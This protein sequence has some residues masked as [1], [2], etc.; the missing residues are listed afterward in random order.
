MSLACVAAP[1]ANAALNPVWLDSS[2]LAEGG[3]ET[4]A[5]RLAS[6]HGRTVVVWKQS[7]GSNTRLYASLRGTDGTWSGAE[8]ISAAGQDV[9]YDNFRVAAD[10]DGDF[11]VGW[12]QDGGNLPVFT[13]T[14]A[15]TSSEWA[16]EP[17]L[18]SESDGAWDFEFSSPAD[19][20][21]VAWYATA[22]D[23]YKVR[24]RTMRPGSDT[25][26]PA[27]VDIESGS[28]PSS[29][30]VAYNASGD[31][32]AVWAA[33]PDS[34]YHL[35]ASRYDAVDATWSPPVDVTAPAANVIQATFLAITPTG[36]A[37]VVWGSESDMIGRNAS[38][39]A[40]SDTWV[41]QDPL[42]EGDRVLVG[43]GLAG[44]RGGNI[45]VGYSEWD[46]A[47]MA[48][49]RPL[50]RIRD[51]ATGAWSTPEQLL[52]DGVAGF[53]TGATA[54]P[55]GN[56]VATLLTTTDFSTVYVTA[57]YRPAGAT[58][59]TDN[60]SLGTMPLEFSHGVPVST[61]D[62]R[63]NPVVV[64]PKHGSGEVLVNA[65]IGD[66][67][68]PELSGLSV[69]TSGTVG[70]PLSFSVSPFDLL[71][72]M[73]TTSWSF[74]DSRD[75]TGT[76]VSHTYDAP[77]SYALTVTSRDL[78]G[79]TSSET[80]TIT[81]TSPPAAPVDEPD[82]AAPAPPKVLA[83]VLEARLSGKTITLNTRVTL[84]AG[85]KC[86]GRATAT[87]SF[88]NTTY[89]TTLKL[90]KVNGKCVGTGTIKLKKTPS[91]RTKLRV[92]V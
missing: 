5:P 62:E 73:D 60:Q 70:E 24:F 66:A 35:R 20:S 75:A 3:S 2:T 52:D 9:N 37:T 92:T 86:T 22:S 40:G 26:D 28:N 33:H 6:S 34:N 25:W 82:D 85:K 51:A 53:M 72:G 65:A 87:T 10:A 57:L 15:N 68:G 76:S 13:L 27:P 7:D 45:V 23:P 1:A 49:T 69:P 43:L 81:I 89:R 78:R 11:T 38:V 4:F 44:D 67:T 79:Q 30:S 50:S 8:P 18:L 91:T 84:R 83:P 17:Q 31:G 32:I 19:G 56:I 80:R 16:D 90:A 77:G 64:W 46:G 59:F 63:G 47:N 74:G 36:A 88:G 54:D 58:S 14:L 61:I 29:L 41:T 71:S 39:A 55:S 12:C 48:T 42:A 21:L